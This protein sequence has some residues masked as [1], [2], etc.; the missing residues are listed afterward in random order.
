MIENLPNE[1]W[2]DVVGFEGLYR[3]S[4]KGR[5]KSLE[6]LVFDSNKW[7]NGYTKKEQLLKDR[8]NGRG[9]RV[10]ELY[11]EGKRSFCKVHRLVAIAFIPNPEN[12]PEVNHEDSDKTNNWDTNLTW[13][14]PSE[15]SC[16]AYKNDNK[17][18]PNL[19][20]RVAQLD[21]DG[22]IIA[23]FESAKAG[24]LAVGGYRSDDVARVTRG[25]R[26]SFKGFGW[27]YL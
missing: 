4:N 10:L 11:K 20:K 14:T 13:V 27:K 7:S 24:A 22:N 25:E 3:V 5:V 17:P 19:N 2:R 21:K 9:Y 26:K 8:D 1:E 16:H 12:K 6:R 23:E 15:N 18:R